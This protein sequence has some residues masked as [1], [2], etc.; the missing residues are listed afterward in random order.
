MKRHFLSLALVFL[1][2]SPAAAQ[3]TLQA[4][5]LSAQA[6]QS[7]TTYQPGADGDADYN[8]GIDATGKPVVEA[9]VYTGS[10]PAPKVIAF[11][12]TVDMAQYLG[13][14]LVPT[15][16]GKIHVARITILPDGR[17]LR[18]GEPL[19]GQA[20]AALRSLCRHEKQPVE[21]T[22]QPLER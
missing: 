5:T 6:C 7:L 18:D 21:P 13:M 22:I 19:Q 12:L 17:I 8:P 20:D 9:D 11:D 15:P 3:D 10:I 16:E 1:I 14:P 4:L 2:V